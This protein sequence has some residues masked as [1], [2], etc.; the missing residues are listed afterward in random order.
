MT[1]DEMWM[2]H[3]EELMNFMKTNRRRPSKYKAEE[4]RMHN[5]YKS[6][7]K[8]INKGK[9]PPHRLEKFKLLLEVAQKYRRRN[10]F[11]VFEPGE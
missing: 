6:T 7:R 1:R 3:Y 8:I 10:Q 4:L 11:D 9:C 2:A 5:W